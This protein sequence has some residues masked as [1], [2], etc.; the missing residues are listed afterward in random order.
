MVQNTASTSAGNASPAVHGDHAGGAHTNPNSPAL[1]IEQATTPQPHEQPQTALAPQNIAAGPSS[2]Y[3]PP[4]QDFQLQ[5]GAANSPCNDRKHDNSAHVNNNAPANL[6]S[7]GGR[8]SQAGCSPYAGCNDESMRGSDRYDSSPDVLEVIQKDSE[9]FWP[10]QQL[11][12]RLAQPPPDDTLSAL[13]LCTNGDVPTAL[14]MLSE[15][16]M[17]VLPDP[18]SAAGEAK[19]DYPSGSSRMHSESGNENSGGH[20]NASAHGGMHTD[21]EGE[22]DAMLVWLW[23]PQPLSYWVAGEVAQIDMCDGETKLSIRTQDA[24][25]CD[26]EQGLLWP[27]RG[28]EPP[29]ASLQQ[30]Q[31][32]SELGSQRHWSSPGTSGELRDAST[33]VD[34]I[35]RH[36][37]MGMTSSRTESGAGMQAQPV[38]AIPLPPEDEDED[39]SRCVCHTVQF[40]CN[41]L[42]AVT[43]YLRLVPNASVGTCIPHCTTVDSTV[44]LSRNLLTCRYRGEALAQKTQQLYMRLNEPLNDIKREISALQR[45][46]DKG[47]NGSSRKRLRALVR[48]LPLVPLLVSDPNLFS[49]SAVCHSYSVLHVLNASTW[50]VSTC[51]ALLRRRENLCA[52]F[53]DA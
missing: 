47:G 41:V 21:N 50:T 43:P 48:I 49:E 1:R 46:I 29:P 36:E 45:T 18:A 38:L 53:A 30:E 34:A 11:R 35:T 16:G 4:D 52:L 14:Q 37:R 32:E 10:L 44:Q 17:K 8:H 24:V 13:L 15:S 42:G 39:L 9:N 40:C 31:Q 22:D 26:V 25:I 28:G 12:T 5:I 33:R 23:R 27:R 51:L 6:H 2:F 20:H 3:S 7:I 19:G